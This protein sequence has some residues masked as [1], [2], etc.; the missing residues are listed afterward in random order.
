MEYG[1]PEE[2]VSDQGS[3]FTSDHY[4]AFAA[5]YNMKITHSSPRYP[6]SNGFI[7]S[8]VKVVENLLERCKTSG[9]DPHIALL[10]YRA[11]PLKPGV[12]SPAELLSQRRFQTTIPVLKSSSMSETQ[13][14]A[15][16]RMEGDK[17]KMTEL[18]DRRAKAYRE[19]QLNE[20]VYVKTDPQSDW[21]QAV[22][23]GTPPEIGP[24]SYSVQLPSGQRFQRN[25]IH[26][27][28]DK[29]KQTAEET[30]RDT[31]PH[32]DA[33]RGGENATA[34]NTAPT[35]ERPTRERRRPD[36]LEYSVMGGQNDHSKS[37]SGNINLVYRKTKSPI[38]H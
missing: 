35:R 15:R 8:M 27:R 11:T 12:A 14:S 18:H 10:M 5:K 25:R 20:P 13:R 38:R 17:Q 22:I 21:K 7:E 16:Q 19:L 23:V 32:A 31:E 2:I 6:R 29:G 37:P 9:S 3:Q 36:R 1:F 26:L 33:E 28:P 34:A 24:R 4:R 30:L